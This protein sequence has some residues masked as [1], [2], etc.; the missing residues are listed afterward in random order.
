MLYAKVYLNK[1]SCHRDDKQ[2]NLFQYKTF[3]VEQI[4]KG[5]TTL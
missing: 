3:K 1:I 4:I 5:K 2:R